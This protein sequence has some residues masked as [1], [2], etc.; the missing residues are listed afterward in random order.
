MPFRANFFGKR[1]VRVDA[2]CDRR[3]H[4]LRRKKPPSLNRSVV[5]AIDSASFLWS[6]DV[7]RQLLFGEFVCRANQKGSGL[8]NGNCVLNPNAREGLVSATRHLLSLCLLTP[9]LRNRAVSPKVPQASFLWTRESAHRRTLKCIPVTSTQPNPFGLSEPWVP[10]ASVR[11]LLAGLCAQIANADSSELISS[12]CASK[13]KR[14]SIVKKFMADL[15]LTQKL[16]VSPF[17]IVLLLVIFGIVAY[18]MFSKQQSS[19]KDVVANRFKRSQ[20]LAGAILDVERISARTKTVYQS[21]K[22]LEGLNKS[23]TDDAQAG[24]KGQPVSQETKNDTVVAFEAVRTLISKMAN[25]SAAT[26]EEKSAFLQANNKLSDYGSA[27]ESL[28]NKIETSGAAEAT[29]DLARVNNNSVVLSAALFSLLHLEEKLSDGQY[30]S[31]ERSYHVGLVVQG[32]ILIVAVFVSVAITMIMKTLILSPITKTIN[33]MESVAEGDLT[34]RIG[35][36]SRDE[37]GEMARQFNIFVEKLQNAIMHVGESSTRVSAAAAALDNATVQMAAGAD[38]AA[39]QINAI[40][41]ASEEMSKTTS[42]IA[43]NCSTA[44]RSAELAGNSVSVGEAVTQETTAV[45]NQIC[46]RVRK[47]S[48]I[49]KDL[50]T[51]SEQIGQI[52]GLINDIADQTNLLA[53]NAAIEAAQVG[54]QG[55][56]FAVV[57]DEVKKLAQRTGQATD[58]IRGTILAMQQETVKAISSMEEGVAEVEKGTTEAA[59]SGETLREILSQ[60]NRVNEEVHQIAVASEEETATT[61]EIAASMQRISEAVRATASRIQENSSAATQL[62]GLARGMQNLVN[63][64]R[65]KQE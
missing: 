21:A 53:L 32:A 39:V 45:M 10:S 33:V 48:S 27:M 60:I 25:L 7:A 13:R 49:M 63:H 51:R 18:V 56:G 47:L 57:A 62:A 9:P 20:S 12:K 37:L 38:E 44:A 58:E 35:V 1:T 34:R 64:F 23:T 30:A 11:G 36:T 31:T 26:N 29:D 16:L 59:K 4:M 28:I 15:P 17:A 55:A 5:A 46:D 40:A 50:G 52:V 61:N 41:A 19:L 24:R 6:L 3:R 42:E 54:E 8:A 14:S 43:R 22:Q 65:T 2:T